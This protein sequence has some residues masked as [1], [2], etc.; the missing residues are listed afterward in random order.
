MSRALDKLD[1]EVTSSVKNGSATK[2]MT[3]DQLLDYAISCS[4]ALKAHLQF[5]TDL[6]ASSSKFKEKID[7]ARKNADKTKFIEIYNRLLTN[8]TGVAKAR[9][10]SSFS[11]ALIEAAQAAVAVLDEVT[12][13][14]DKLFVDK[15][16][17][18][19][20]TKISHVAIYGVMDNASTLAAFM[21]AYINAFFASCPSGNFKLAP[22][23]AS[24]LDD[25][26]E[27]VGDICCRMING[28]MGKTF[29]A[30]I[31]RFKKSGNDTSVLTSDNQSAVKFAKIGTEVSESDIRSGCKGL[32]IF[33]VIGDFIVDFF[34]NRARKQRA[35]R[36][37]HKARVEYLQMELEGEDPN[38]PRYKK[39]IKII[40]NYNDMIDRL[41]QKLDKYYNEEED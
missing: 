13:N 15:T 40:K 10:E 25:K 17:N 6:G 22:Y 35:L 34:D 38:S 37:Q 21:E 3:R 30:A 33:R 19:Y 9:Q 5:F 4:A 2:N 12:I 28:K 20:N 39:I 16:F 27:A 29:A 36:E 11:G 14:I 7:L 26:V 31:L 8:L 1:N 32:H 24:Y 23:Q 18:L 41:N